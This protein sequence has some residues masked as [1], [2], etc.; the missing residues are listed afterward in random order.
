[1]TTGAYTITV[2]VAARADAPL[3]AAPFRASMIEVARAHPLPPTG[4]ARSVP[5]TLEIPAIGVRSRLQETGLNPDGTIAVPPPGP[6][7]G[8]AA[9]Y[10]NSPTPGQTGPAVLEGHLDTADGAPSVFY[11]LGELPPG[12]Q[13]RV[14]R[15]DGRTAVFEVTEVARFAR[16]EFPTS[17]VYGD[18]DHPELRVLT[19]GGPIDPGSG[20]YRDNVVVFATL[21][22]VEVPARLGSSERTAA[23]S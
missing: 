12:A 17:A 18:V 5:T 1:M 16:A 15:A 23:L 14:T 9:W 19:C 13:I 11:R 21:S 2:G 22:A 7:Y 3:V 8:V 20:Q 10:R 6:D 4:L